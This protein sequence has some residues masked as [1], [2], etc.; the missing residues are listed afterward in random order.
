MIDTPIVERFA[1]GQN[2]ITEGIVSTK[3]YMIISG[4][5]KVTKKVGDKQIIV[6]NQ[7]IRNTYE[8]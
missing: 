1:D 2:I 8:F 6:G 3:A 7:K 5:V 4:K